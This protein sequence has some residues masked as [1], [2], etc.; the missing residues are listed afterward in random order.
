[1]YYKN[2]YYIDYGNEYENY[3]IDDDD[4]NLQNTNDKSTFSPQ[5]LYTVITDK[6]LV[7]Q[8]EKLIEKTTE[9]TSLSRDDAILALIHFHW[10]WNELEE[11]W[12]NGES[13]IKSEIGITQSKFSQDLTKQFANKDYC[14]I[15]L[16]PCFP[17]ID[18][19]CK[20]TFCLDC[21]N[22]YLRTRIENTGLILFTTCPQGN[23]NVRV[24]ESVFLNHY[25]SD[26]KSCFNIRLAIKKNF[27]EYNKDIK[28]CL[29]CCANIRCDSK[30]N[31]EVDC[32]CGNTF[33]FRCLR[34]GHKPCPCEMVFKWDAKVNRREITTMPRTENKECP[35]CKTY[36]TKTVDHNDV[37]CFNCK[38][39]FCW[40]CLQGTKLHKAC[41]KSARSDLLKLKDIKQINLMEVI[42]KQ[43]YEFK[44]FYDKYM[45]YNH[46]YEICIKL[47]LTNEDCEDKFHLFRKVPR[48][49]LS[50]LREGLEI[51][52]KG[53]RLLRNSYVF[54]Y[55]LK[56]SGLFEH[57]QSILETNVETLYGYYYK[58][59]YIILAELENFEDFNTQ[60]TQF[61]NNVISF[62]KATSQFVDNFINECEDNLYE[63]T[64]SDELEKL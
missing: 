64:N 5:K 39:E 43:Y 32:V 1:M 34:D 27:L 61:K 19:C 54:A 42:N 57:I 13:E 36:I 45:H 37:S 2:D 7:T 55:Y 53:M 22:S 48:E 58:D 4:Y 8:R 50:F 63:W 38:F 20:H 29:T 12:Y 9:Y 24:P 16:T 49:E 62:S 6:E 25:E 3:Q 23:C 18:L 47:R 33:C 52:I 21:W 44:H 11:H 14:L 60:F 40:L 35:K 15:C 26:E 28:S 46:S 17:Y 59:N 30:S 41:S 51:L 31:I 56:E 10:N